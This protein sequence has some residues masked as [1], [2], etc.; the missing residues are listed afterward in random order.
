MAGEV[1]GDYHGRGS[2]YYHEVKIREGRLSSAERVVEAVMRLSLL[3]GELTK[4]G[5][6]LEWPPVAIME[7]GDTIGFVARSVAMQF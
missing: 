1:G 2:Y 7:D 4:A 6:R 3:D 5:R